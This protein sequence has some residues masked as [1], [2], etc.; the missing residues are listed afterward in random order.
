MGIILKDISLMEDCLFC[1][2]SLGEGGYREWWQF[3]G[4]G[5]QESSQHET[6]VGRVDHAFRE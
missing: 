3:T 1:S 5:L 2:A 6:G 4:R